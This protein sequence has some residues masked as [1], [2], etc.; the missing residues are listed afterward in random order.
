MSKHKFF[1]LTF[2]TLS[3]IVLL[4]GCGKSSTDSSSSAAF[5]KKE[6][7]K[8]STS[9]LNDITLEEAAGILEPQTV[10]DN[11]PTLSVPTYI[12]QIDGVWFIVDCYHDRVI[13]SEQLG[14]PIE[15]WKIMIG[16][17]SQPH[18]IASDGKV[19]LLDDTE[20]NRVIV[21]E[22]AEG[23][24][25]ATQYFEDIGVRPHYTVYDEN[26]STFYVW[27][28]ENGEMYL[29]RHPEDSTKMYLTEIRKIDELSDLYVRSFT[30]IGDEILFVSG[31]SKD[32]TPGTVLKCDLN[33]FKVKKSYTVPDEL[34]GMVQITPI[35]DMFYITTST[36]LYGNQDYAT[37]VRTSSLEELSDGKYEDIYADYFVGGGTPYYIS[38]VGDTYYLTEHRLP[39][40]SIWSFK[41]KDG[42]VT[43]VTALY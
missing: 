39:G 16:M 38:Q 33:T 30:I 36:D 19:Y 28:S 17:T 6:Y 40:H 15:D 29:F 11:H 24:F 8:E 22:K 18:T 13:Y 26:T 3:A 43:D 7:L 27:S 34:A 12:T 32:G 2:L 14:L 4:A 35:D 10:L 37:I 20:N 5:D 25:I 1:S 41:V 31:V 21:F 9:V 23:K 42:S